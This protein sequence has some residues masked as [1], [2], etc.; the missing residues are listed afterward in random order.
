[1]A[2]GFTSAPATRLVLGRLRLRVPLESDQFYVAVF[3]HPSSG[4]PIMM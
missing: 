3:A 2:S 4:L 1:V